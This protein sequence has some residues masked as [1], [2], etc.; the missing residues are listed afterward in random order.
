MQASLRTYATIA[1]IRVD[2]SI[3]MKQRS[4][5]KAH[6][7]SQPTQQLAESGAVTKDWGGRL[8]VA[9]TMPNS[10]YVGMS[11]LALQILYRTLNADSRRRLRAH[12]LGTRRGQRWTSPPIA[13]ESA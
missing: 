2:S 7:R 9:L 8:R 12:F 5:Q 1:E 3:G 11:S 13:R 10:Y 4:K 6:H